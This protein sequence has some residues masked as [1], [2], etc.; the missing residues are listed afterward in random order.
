MDESYLDIEF[1]RADDL[2]AQ[3]LIEEGKEVL[4]S[5][6]VENP[7][8]GK[9]HNHLGWI[10]KIKE[11]NLTSA[12]NHYRTCTGIWCHLYEL[13]LSSF[14]RKKVCGTGS[15]SEESRSNQRCQSDK[16]IE[17]MGILL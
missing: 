11:N 3:E 16:F 8:Y 5:I 13:C 14:R 17:R 10:S 1:N 6:L 7:K 9:A 2:I 12:E 15:T 4:Q